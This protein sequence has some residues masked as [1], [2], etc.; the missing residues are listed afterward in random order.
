MFAKPH[1]VKGEISLITDDN[2]ADMAGDP[3]IVCNIDGIYVPFFIE[4][5]RQKSASNVLVKFENIDSAEKVRLL[6]GKTAFVPSDLLPL[7]DDKPFLRGA[8]IG[9]TVIDDNAGTLGEVIAVDDSTPN[10]LLKI[11]Y[12]SSE[13][14]VPLSLIT[15]IQHQTMYTSL[16]DGFIEFYT[17][18]YEKA[19]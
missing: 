15:S 13:M 3:Y 5:F 11:E 17:E 12:K 6:T 19:T 9:F 18:T 1:G 4:T 2:P 7:P 16:P 14:L 10:I 8:M